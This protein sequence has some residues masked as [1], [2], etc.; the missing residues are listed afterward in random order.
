LNGKKGHSSHNKQNTFCIIVCLHI[1]PIS[2][3]L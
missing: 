2:K 3:K 1:A